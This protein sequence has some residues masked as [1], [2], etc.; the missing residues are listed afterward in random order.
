MKRLQT[1]C[2]AG[3]FALHGLLFVLLVAGSG[4]LSPH[5]EPD[6]QSLPVVDF[7][8]TR[9][10]EANEAGG[11]DPQ[12][13]APAPRPAPRTPVTPP[14]TTPTPPAPAPVPTPA[15]PVR[16]VEKSAPPEPVTKPAPKVPPKPVPVDPSPITDATARKAAPK[17]KPKVEINKTMVTRDNRAAEEARKRAAEQAEA[18]EAAEA[19]RA[20]AAA[21]QVRAGQFNHALGKLQSDLSGRSVVA[22]PY[23]PGGGGETYA[24]YGL[25]VRMI[26]QRAWRP[27]TEVPDNSSVVTARVVIAKDGRI[28]SADIVGKSGVSALDRSVAAALGRV[29]TIG[30]PFPEGSTDEQKTFLIDFDLQAKRGTG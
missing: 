10:I 18:A 2:L 1:Q 6:W 28:M 23:G 17:P 26:Y 30:R 22:V 25:Y 8:P 14:V 29:T 3:S 20:L 24:G 5:H 21:R 11:G 4:F 12:G 7:I 16:T 27:P 9:L 19:A 13:G 15:P